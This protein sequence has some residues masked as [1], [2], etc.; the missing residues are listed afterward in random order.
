M[1]ALLSLLTSR[2]AGPIASVLAVLF[3]SVAGCQTVRLKGAQADLVRAEQHLASAREQLVRCQGNRMALEA[4]IATQNAEVEAFARIQSER[5]ALAE[6]AAQQAAKGRVDAEIRAAK[7][8]KNQPQ[9]ID[10]CARFMSADRAVL[11]SL[12]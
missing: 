7:L 12:R 10:A 5:V 3:L 2:A 8:L 9:G 1:I 4:S 6:K 11:D